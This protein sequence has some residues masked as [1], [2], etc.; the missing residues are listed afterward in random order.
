MYLDALAMRA[1]HGVSTFMSRYIYPGKSSPLLLHEYLRQVAQSPFELVSVDD[2]RHNYYLTCREWARRL[3]AARDEVVTPLGRAAV[4]PV[5]ALPV[6]LGGRLRHRP[7]PGLSLG[8]A[9]AHLRPSSPPRSWPA[10]HDR[11]SW[12][13]LGP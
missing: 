8:P 7:G 5:P 11:G 4:P 2:D 3:D 12:R 1:K 6:G 13:S 10:G 9:H